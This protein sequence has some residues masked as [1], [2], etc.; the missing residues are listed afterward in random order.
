MAQQVKRAAALTAEL[1]TQSEEKTAAVCDRPPG[2]NELAGHVE[3]PIVGG[4]WLTLPGHD[5]RARPWAKLHLRRSP[6]SIRAEDP[7]LLQ[8]GSVAVSYKRSIEHTSP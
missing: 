5:E 8:E 6:M 7:L 1:A 4:R 2:L 3:A